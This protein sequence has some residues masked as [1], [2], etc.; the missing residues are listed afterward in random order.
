MRPVPG[1]P[2]QVTGRAGA[3][4]S[5]HVVSVRGCITHSTSSAFHEAVQAVT[6]PRLILDLSEVPTF[7]SM[8]IG[9]LVRVYVSCNK[10]GRKL[11]LVGLNRQLQNVL[12]ITGV[13][14]LFESYP[15][16]AEAESA[17]G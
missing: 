16:I 1:E 13:E 17:L 3:N 11:A 5:V 12:R 10:C 6:T 4:G 2:F 8:A 7:D 15:S 14:A 9:A